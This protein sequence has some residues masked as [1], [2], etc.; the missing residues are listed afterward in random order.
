ML[1]NISESVLSENQGVKVKNFPGATNKKKTQR[2]WRS[3]EKQ[4]GSINCICWQKW[5]KKTRQPTEAI[6]ENP[7]KVQR[8]FTIS[9]SIFISRNGNVTQ[10]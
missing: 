1:N 2:N 6:Q 4:S 10:F 5:F 9:V 7:Q 3:A 8:N